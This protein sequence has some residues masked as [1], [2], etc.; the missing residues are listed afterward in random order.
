VTANHGALAIPAKVAATFAPADAPGQA[1]RLARWRRF[2]GA[3]R[4]V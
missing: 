1:D 4:G 3:I 2:Y